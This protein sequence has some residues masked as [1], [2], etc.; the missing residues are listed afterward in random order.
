MAVSSLGQLRLN[1]VANTRQFKRGMRSAQ[2]SARRTRSRLTR[3]KNAVFS[4][5]G[6]LVAIG[7]AAVLRGM[8]SMV[9]AF[10]QQ[11]EAV[12]SL[13]AALVA[14]G[15]DGAGALEL[16][17]QRAAEFQQITTK[18]D[19]AIIA[20]TASLGQ[21]AKEL[22]VQDLADA[23]KAIIGIADTFLK[24]DVQNA[25]QL[26]GKT[27]GSTTNALTRYGIQVDTAA[28]QSEKL[29]QV[30]DQSNVF[31]EV[32]RERAKTTAGRIQQ[33]KNAYGDLQEAIGGVV[34]ELLGFNE[35]AKNSKNRIEEWTASINE[36]RE[37]IVAVLRAFAVPF[38]V[39]K[40]VVE[41]AVDF[42]V[43]AFSQLVGHIIQIL[44]LPVKA[45]NFVIR[46]LNRL[47]KVD[48]AEITG[49][50]PTAWFSMASA[51]AQ[52]FVGDIKD[53]AAAFGIDLREAAESAASS[54]AAATSAARNVTTPG[55]GS[56]GEAGPFAGIANPVV[57]LV[58]TLGR[59]SIATEH[60]ANQIAVM[61]EKGQRL[62]EM[63]Q[64]I[65]AA[66]ANSLVNAVRSAK[67][68]FKAFADFAINQLLRLAAQFAVFSGLNALFPGSGFVANLGKS[69]GFLAE[70]GPARRGQPYVV[71]E[72][73]PELF[74]PNQSGQVV[75][76]GGMGG[77]VVLQAPSGGRNLEDFIRDPY[78][79]E[80]L[81][82]W[83][84][85]V[86]SVGGMR[87]EVVG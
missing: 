82:E 81:T 9:D 61:R 58:D 43:T 6:A 1:L 8:K 85:E 47:P 67:D 77:T 2:N 50:D 64:N 35:G 54:V 40:N 66:F 59:A 56:S 51:G 5:Q 80:L 37:A 36:N 38:K 49:L 32:S 21:L 76:N 78:N 83:I 15:R 53:V 44:N 39:L 11:E 20:A 84:R 16:L 73:G 46:Q 31:F 55:A 70:G 48:I 28:T 86:A 52:Q 72:Q 26:L 62:A 13:Q 57:R 19:E 14:T 34:V 63:G 75:P 45:A 33:L 12:I 65:A 79:I 41:L 71:G 7:G 69:L 42:I 87:M 30:L 3:L 25:A 29:A 22:S 18:G 17:T 27:L 4:L 24:G 10:A 74:V 68:A 60:A 23:Q